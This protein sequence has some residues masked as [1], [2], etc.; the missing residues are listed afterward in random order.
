M[1]RNLFRKKNVRNTR[2]F[3]KPNY[4]LHNTN[5]QKNKRTV[6]YDNDPMENFIRIRGKYKFLNDKLKSEE[7][8]VK[9][10]ITKEK[11]IPKSKGYDINE[12]K[13]FADNIKFDKVTNMVLG[14][15]FE[16]DI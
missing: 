9:K 10:K 14:V 8:K 5:I 15:G 11:T 13:K 1:I 6:L 4:K 12:I 3:Y 2:K 16:Y 7:I